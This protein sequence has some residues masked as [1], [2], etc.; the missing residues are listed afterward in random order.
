M[1]CRAAVRPLRI[2][3][4][5]RNAGWR[6]S[7]VFSP[8]PHRQFHDDI[9]EADSLKTRQC[10][11]PPRPREV[12][13]EPT[14]PEEEMLG[15]GNVLDELGLGTVPRTASHGTGTEIDKMGRLQITHPALS[16]RPHKTALLLSRAPTSLTE[17]D[18]LRILAP[19]KHLEGWKSQ[20][21]L[22]EVIPIRNLKTLDRTDGWLLL[23][24][25]PASAAAYQAAVHRLRELLRNNTPFYPASDLVLPSNYSVRGSLGFNLQDYTLTTPWQF[26]L[27]TADHFPFGEWVNS[28]IKVHRAVTG[29]GKRDDH[30]HTMSS[31]SPSVPGY[32][33]RVCIS[34]H[35]FLGL[36]KQAIRNFLIWDGEVRSIHWD[37]IEGMDSIVSLD[38]DQGADDGL[39]RERRPSKPKFGEYDVSNWRILFESASEAR[40]FVRAWNMKDYPQSPDAP[41]CDPPARIKAEALFW[42]DG[43]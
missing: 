22:E 16:R 15:Q 9:T 12:E 27:L 18:F 6:P 21:G 10:P 4:S 20:G 37:L 33:V 38:D 2:L 14:L 40:R 25:N 34:R 29:T 13:P 30:Q 39:V 43:F 35:I 11:P 8:V 41:Y 7:P 28:C 26:P 24:T 19:G 23:F 31:P 5:G 1:R 32:P 3:L 17:R 36:T 42:D